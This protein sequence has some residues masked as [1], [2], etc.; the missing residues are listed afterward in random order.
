MDFTTTK[1][2]LDFTVDGVKFETKNAVAAG[3]IFRMQ[4]T[5]AKMGSQDVNAVAERE[6]AFE[7][8]KKT[9][10]KILTKAAWKRFEPLLEG[11]C[12]DKSTPIDPL[13]LIEITQW[14]VGEGLGKGNTPP[15]DS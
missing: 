11:T 3:I 8:L 2:K 4:S 10:E 6:E 7:E 9:Y 12:D 5:F 14:I 13:K 1:N 15:Q